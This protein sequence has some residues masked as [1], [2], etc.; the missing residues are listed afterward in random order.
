MTQ[1]EELDFI[2]AANTKMV[3]QAAV[4]EA[5]SPVKTSQIVWGCIHRHVALC[6]HVCSRL[7]YV[8]KLYASWPT[9]VLGRRQRALPTM[10]GQSPTR[11]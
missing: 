6:C 3:Y 8:V 10:F 11:H 7:R 1:A 4:E 9:V 2:Q 5:K